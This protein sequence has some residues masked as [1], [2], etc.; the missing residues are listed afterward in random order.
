MTDRKLGKE[1]LVKSFNVNKDLTDND[2]DQPDFQGYLSTYGNSDRVGDIIEKGAFDK[3]IA[4]DSTTTL[5]YQHDRSNVIGVLNLSLDDK[6]VFFKAYLTK[7]LDS[8]KDTKANLKI[9]ALKYMSISMNIINFEY[10]G[11]NP[12]EQLN[13]MIVKEADILE[14]SIVTVPANIEA[15]ITSVKEFRQKAFDE[16]NK[17]NKELELKKQLLKEFNKDLNI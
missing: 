15:E 4:R 14:G 8:Y 10:R 13:P 17:K 2:G 6:G 9:G 12:I 11:D 16:F 7:E 1:L 3:S 5:L